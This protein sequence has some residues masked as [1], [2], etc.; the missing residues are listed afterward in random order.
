MANGLSLR[1]PACASNLGSSVIGL[2]D[3][4]VW[5]K[6]CVCGTPLA[7]WC[8]VCMLS[9]SH[10]HKVQKFSTTTVW[11]NNAVYLHSVALTSFADPCAGDLV[12]LYFIEYGA[13]KVLQ[14][15][16]CLQLGFISGGG[17]AGAVQTGDGWRRIPILPILVVTPDNQE[18]SAM[19]LTI[20]SRFCVCYED[21][22]YRVSFSNFLVCRVEHQ[23]SFKA[24]LN[25]LIRTGTKTASWK[26][27]H[28]LMVGSDDFD[29]QR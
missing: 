28:A 1:K 29:E 2:H 8:G 24:W 4:S 14:R 13:A 11:V 17:G 26:N 27:C 5:N 12:Q 6:G 22:H 10:I 3:P 19:L 9:K 7:S 18:A 16:H 20:Y 21:S 15:V 23:G 25:K